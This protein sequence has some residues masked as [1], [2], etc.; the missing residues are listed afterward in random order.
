MSLGGAVSR[1]LAILAALLPAL[2]ACG[3]PSQAV[4]TCPPA[5]TGDVLLL[6]AQ[7]VPSA[8]QVPCIEEFPAGWSFGGQEIESGSSEFWLFSDRAGDRAVTVTLTAS[9]DVRTTTDVASREASASVTAGS[10]S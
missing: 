9:C 8:T 2:A 6:M 7:S 3:T 5:G 4:P 1:R 10:P